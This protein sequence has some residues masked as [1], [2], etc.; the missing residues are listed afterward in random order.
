M[1]KMASMNCP[2]CGVSTELQG[3]FC[4]NCGYAFQVDGLATSSPSQGQQGRGYPSPY[5][6][7]GSVSTPSSPAYSANFTPSSPGYQAAG[8]PPPPPPYPASNTP[9]SPI[10][11]T[12]GTPPP[13]PLSSPLYPAR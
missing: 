2:K 6:A 12:A 11:P 5:P 3:A 9:S 10:Y 1:Y 4:G 13:P 7:A 8:S